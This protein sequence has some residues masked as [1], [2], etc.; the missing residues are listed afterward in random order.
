VGLLT[1]GESLTLL[2]ALRS[3]F[4]PPGFL[5]PSCLSGFV[6]VVVVCLFGWLVG[7]SRQGFSV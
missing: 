4:P 2:P 3:L 1:L 7:F 5:F 6:V